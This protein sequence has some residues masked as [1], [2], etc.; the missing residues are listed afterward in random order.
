[1]KG[2]T[3]STTFQQRAACINL[4]PPTVQAYLVG[5]TRRLLT[6]P[7]VGQGLSLLLFP[8]ISALEYHIL[9]T[10]IGRVFGETQPS[11]TMFHNVD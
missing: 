8:P 11:F 4:Q 1:M 5:L 3:E 7:T 6:V 2:Q 9:G 10:L